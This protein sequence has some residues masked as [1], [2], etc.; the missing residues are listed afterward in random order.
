MD[1][2]KGIFYLIVATITLEIL[3]YVV[4]HFIAVTEIKNTFNKLNYGIVSRKDLI[5]LSDFNF[6]QWSIPILENLGLHNIDLINYKLSYNFQVKGYING[7]LSYIKFVKLKQDSSNPND[8][9]AFFTVGRPDL[10]KFVGTME[11]DN[12]KIGYVL[13]NGN[14]SSEANDYAKTM[15]SNYCLKLIDGCE[16]TRI[17]R[18]TQN[19]YLTA[20]VD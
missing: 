18:R 13:T 8:E 9:D 1:I 5:S 20:Y 17:H 15:P 4:N 6:I 14:F 12:V 3:R 7:K 16:L 19:Q 2:W 10:Q 11:R